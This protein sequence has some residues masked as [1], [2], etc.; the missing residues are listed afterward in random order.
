MGESRLSSFALVYIKYD[1]PIDLED[2]VDLFARLHPGL[3]ELS[4]L[5]FTSVGACSVVITPQRVPLV[6]RRGLITLN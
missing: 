6:P 5:M 3:M 4:N 1:M 2:V